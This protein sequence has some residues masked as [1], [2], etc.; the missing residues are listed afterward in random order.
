M[1][2]QIENEIEKEEVDVQPEHIES[3]NND[4][5][6]KALSDL[7][8]WKQRAREMEQQ[9][10]KLQES[11]KA[12]ENEKLENKEEYKKLYLTVKEENDRLKKQLEQMGQ[13]VFFDKK[14]GKVESAAREAGMRE[15]QVR[16]LSRYP[17]Y[18]DLVEVETSESGRMS[19]NGVQEMLGKIRVERPEWFSR[20]KA[21]NINSA[22]PDGGI[23]PEKTLS[24]IEELELEKKDPV[25]YRAYCKKKYGIG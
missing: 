15:I 21:P 11:I 23:P 9:I 18:T 20:G 10:N 25:A 17:E 16:D 24:A 13:N 8:K 3:P 22:L 4:Q 5:H 1:S 14:M 2:E 7:M 6:K 19:V 12:K